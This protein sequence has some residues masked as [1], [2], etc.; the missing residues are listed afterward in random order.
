[1]VGLLGGFECECGW[2]GAAVAVG[3]A[4]GAAV[5]VGVKTF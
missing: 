4:V 2:V 3:A 1:M 5:G